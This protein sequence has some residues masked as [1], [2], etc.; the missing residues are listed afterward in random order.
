M[1]FTMLEDFTERSLLFP[2]TTSLEL[3]KTS[4]TR[5]K[6]HPTTLDTLDFPE[7][8]TSISP[9]NPLDP[10]PTETKDTLFSEPESHCS[11]DLA[12]LPLTL[13]IWDT[14]GEPMLPGTLPSSFWL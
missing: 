14:N 10:S 11:E 13:E 7:I 1:E 5:D 3:D 12:Q 4:T 9:L 2:K 8:K 6:S